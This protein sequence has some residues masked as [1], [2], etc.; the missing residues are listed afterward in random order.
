MKPCLSMPHGR[1]RPAK[2]DNLDG[3]VRLLHDEK[4]RRYLCDGFALPRETVAG[5]LARSDA[6][7]SQG[8]GLW[9]IE[10]TH[11]A[12]AG[13]AGLEPVS[14]EAGTAPAMAGGIEPIIALNPEHWGQGLASEAMDAL[15]VYARRSL[16][17]PRLVAAVDQPNAGSHRLM[18][19]CGFTVMGKAPGTA[20][21]LVLYKL[22][23]GS[24]EAPE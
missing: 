12:F 22:L 6:L 15:I 4:V 23:L 10:H 5:M 1:L 19:R 8:L 9:V 13:I 21:E 18:Q 16:R 17:L 14:A 11:N 24:A 2:T 20:N 3:L 7:D